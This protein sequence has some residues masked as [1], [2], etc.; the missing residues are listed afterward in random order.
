MGEEKNLHFTQQM[1]RLF[2]LCP[3]FFLLLLFVPH[4]WL[5]MDLSAC[6]RTMLPWLVWWTLINYLHC[7]TVAVVN[8]ENKRDE[9]LFNKRS[10]LFVTPTVNNS[11][12]TPSSFT[13]WNNRVPAFRN[14]NHFS[15]LRPTLFLFAILLW[16]NQQRQRFPRNWI[17]LNV[18]DSCRQS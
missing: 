10:N 18:W 11:T 16:A 8:V 3:S 14:K 13:L 4:H 15:T 1:S 9:W 12:S 6:P 5:L 2:K 7:S 17:I